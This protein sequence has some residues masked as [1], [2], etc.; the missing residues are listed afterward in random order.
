MTDRKCQRIETK[1]V[2]RLVGSG[3][4]RDTFFSDSLNMCMKTKED[5]S[6]K[7]ASLNMLM[8]TNKICM[9]CEYVYENTGSYR[10]FTSY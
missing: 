4:P 10:Q 5:E 1:Q 7:L 8:K 6:D 9:F 2:A 3:A